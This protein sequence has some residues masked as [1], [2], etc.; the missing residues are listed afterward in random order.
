MS[1]LNIGPC[2]HFPHS[3]EYD[4]CEYDSVEYFEKLLNKF[5]LI[6]YEREGKRKNVWSTEDGRLLLITYANPFITKGYMSGVLICCMDETTF[7]EFVFEFD[8][9]VQCCK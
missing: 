2:R 5:K 7:G 1:I 9:H 8:S 6:K 3:I 4:L